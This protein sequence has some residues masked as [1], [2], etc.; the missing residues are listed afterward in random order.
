MAQVNDLLAKGT[1]PIF[2]AE[3]TSDA[4]RAHQRRRTTYLGNAAKRFAAVCN[5][6]EAVLFTFGHSF[7]VSD[8]HISYAVANGQVGTVYLGVF[9]PR[10]RQRGY[11]LAYE[12]QAA[13]TAKCL[14]AVRVQQYDASTC[15]VW[16]RSLI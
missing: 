3:A 9:G 1:F 13:R 4:K 11:D 10:D 14:P 5:D 16:P 15:R 6:N 7:G 12:W 2:V 8:N